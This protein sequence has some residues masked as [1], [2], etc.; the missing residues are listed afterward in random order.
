LTLVSRDPEYRNTVLVSN[1]H[2][3]GLSVVVR[4]AMVEFVVDLSPA[5]SALPLL[6]AELERTQGKNGFSLLPPT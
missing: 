4:L 5:Q 6:I 2:K 1:R 3:D